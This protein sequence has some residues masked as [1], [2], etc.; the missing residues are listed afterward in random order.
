MV[1]TI[2]PRAAPVA[3]DPRP[4]AEA[5]KKAAVSVVRDAVPDM[6]SEAADIVAD[7]MVDTRIYDEK[8]YARD[9]SNRWP[10]HGHVAMKHAGTLA[11]MDVV[12]CFSYN[13]ASVV[14]DYLVNYDQ[15]TH[16][17]LGFQ[18]YCYGISVPRVLITQE[19]ALEIL[20]FLHGPDPFDVFVG[21]PE[22][23]AVSTCWHPAVLKPGRVIDANGYSNS[24]SSKVF[25]EITW[26][27]DSDDDR[28]RYDLDWDPC[29]IFLRMEAHPFQRTRENYYIAHFIQRVNS[30]TKAELAW[31]N[32]LLHLKVAFRG[33][34]KLTGT[35]SIAE[36]N[37]AVHVVAP[38]G[39]SDWRL[40]WE[41]STGT[42]MS[43]CNHFWNNDMHH[44]L[45]VRKFELPR[46]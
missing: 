45:G 22:P 9:C 37:G 3:D 26:A 15:K 14:A 31:H 20:N 10:A 7:Y 43:V 18:R 1:T 44:V 32:K 27:F 4:Y 35:C 6:P 36:K 33:I 34:Q 42:G 30:A 40:G 17:E 29:I 2:S 46:S 12:P 8:G 24:L 13:V 19:K 16:F 39:R 25:D 28:D 38:D 11:V 23:R 5:M 41:D 21:S